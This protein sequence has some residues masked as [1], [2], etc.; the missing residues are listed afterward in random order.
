MFKAY[1]NLWLAL[2][3]LV[4]L[5]PLG[6]LAGGTAFGEWGVEELGEEAGFIPEGLAR[7]SNI[8]HAVLP[9][10]S[11]PGMDA[12]LGAAAGYILSAIIGAGLV[13]AIMAVLYRMI[14]E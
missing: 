6:L 5:S 8:G 4:L 9:D 13:A 7:L 11:I 14:K 12:G 10:Y 2:G 1:K 3:F